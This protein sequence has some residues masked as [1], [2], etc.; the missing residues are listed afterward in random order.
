[1]KTIMCR[2]L[3]TP[4]LVAPL[5]MA[6]DRQETRLG[7]SDSAPQT[8]CIRRDRCSDTLLKGFFN[9]YTYAQTER[10]LL[11][12]TDSVAD[13]T[14]ELLKHHGIR[15]TLH[16]VFPAFERT[17]VLEGTISPCGVVK[18]AYVNPPVDVVRQIVEGH[19]GGTISGDDFGVFFGTF[20]GARLHAVMRFYT[21]QPIH[22]PANDIFETPVVGPVR[23]KWTIDLLVDE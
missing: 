8:A 7:A 13:A 4:L 10:K 5:V 1:M 2:L 19:T 21:A 14:L 22:W 12:D 18:M 20:D 15:L 16:E 6:G 23:W 3:V 11:Q 9:Y 17:T